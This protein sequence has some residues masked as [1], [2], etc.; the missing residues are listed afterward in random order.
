MFVHANTLHDYFFFGD[1]YLLI[2]RTEFD[3]SVCVKQNNLFSNT[4]YELNERK[5][6]CI[7]YSAVKQ[8]MHWMSLFKEK[9][10]EN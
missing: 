3:L 4:C 2:D 6:A 8:I 5:L 9:K 1:R 7:L 10:L